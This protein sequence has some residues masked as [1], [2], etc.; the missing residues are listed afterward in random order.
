MDSA[1][2]YIVG[3][4]A[5]GV[6]VTLATVAWSK[7]TLRRRQGGQSMVEYAIIA[8]IV[9]VIAVGAV[10]LLGE[11]VNLAFSRAETSID[12]AGTP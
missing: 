9:A 10:K 1:V 2:F 12:D 3:V 5:F 11:R 7:R 8:A 4:A 6:V